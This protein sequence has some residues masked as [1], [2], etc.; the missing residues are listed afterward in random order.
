MRHLSGLTLLVACAAA[1][2][3]VQAA[4]P[5]PFTISVTCRPNPAC[6]FKGKK[7]YVNIAIENRSEKDV[8]L[9]KKYM[10]SSGPDVKI[11]DVKTKAAHYTHSSLGDY[12]LLG[13]FEP[14][15]AR[16]TIVMT[17][18]IILDDIITYREK[19]VDLDVE[20]SFGG[21]WKILG[22]SGGKFDAIGRFKIRGEDTL[23]R[24]NSPART[25]R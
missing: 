14:I 22:E 19:F 20:V 17:D 8:L 10:D 3:P 23:A 13:D 15:P 18:V 6:V 25:K 1:Q 7:L 4:A 11:T 12:D 9:T 2:L 16:E 24:R 21:K 5:T